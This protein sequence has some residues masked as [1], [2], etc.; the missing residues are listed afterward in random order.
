MDAG[1]AASFWKPQARPWVS[2][3]GRV[4]RCT[5][6]EDS[7]KPGAAGIHYQVEKE[8]SKPP[9]RKPAYGAPTKEEERFLSAQADAFAGAKAEE[10]VGLL[11]SK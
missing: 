7:L 10:E 4:R 9:T 5:Q 6:L 3:W 11:R 1:I 2:V 8:G